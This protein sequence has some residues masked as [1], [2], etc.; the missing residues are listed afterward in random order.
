MPERPSLADLDDEALLALSSDE[1]CDTIE[2]EAKLLV[3]DALDTYTDVMRQDEDHSA[4]VKAAD[5]IMELAG[6]RKQQIALP[7]GI[8][9]EVF[10]L[11]I[12]GLGQLA[13]IARDSAQSAAILKNVTPAKSDPRLVPQD[14]LA[15]RVSRIAPKTD[16]DNDKVI[17]GYSH[18]RYEIKER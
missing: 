15:P 5:K 9:Q 12:A 2:D 3:S 7:Q 18:E 8:S 10:A 6:V 1:F 13:G 11:A 4:R 14:F 17:E 16:N